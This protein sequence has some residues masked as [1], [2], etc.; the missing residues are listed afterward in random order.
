MSLPIILEAILLQSPCNPNWLYKKLK[1][2]LD[3]GER[4]RS[5]LTGAWCT[6]DPGGLKTGCSDTHYWWPN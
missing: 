1:T 2:T 4:E 3:W 5:L 6:A